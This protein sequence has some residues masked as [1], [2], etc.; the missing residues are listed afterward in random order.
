M[1]VLEQSHQNIWERQKKDWKGILSV[2]RG[3]GDRKIKP[4]YSN[5]LLLL[6]TFL[7]TINKQ[8]TVIIV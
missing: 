7:C 6:L 2:S 5:V 4:N 1:S 3:A 8:A